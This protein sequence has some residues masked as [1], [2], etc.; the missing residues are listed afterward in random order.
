MRRDESAIFVFAHGTN[1]EVLLLIEPLEDSWQYGLARMTGAET[2]VILDDRV[3]WTK[4]SMSGR[5]YSWL[6]D[7]TAEKHLSELPQSGTDE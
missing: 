2:T 6:H 3:V 5:R 4:L 7:Y 1:P